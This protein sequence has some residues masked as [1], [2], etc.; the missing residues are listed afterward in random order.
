MEKITIARE[1]KLALYQKMVSSQPDAVVKGDTIPYTSQNGNMY[2]FLTK[3]SVV[4]LRLPGVERDRF[5]E[6]Y[7]TGLVHQYGIV[8]KEY[9]VVPDNLLKNAAEVKAWFRISHEYVI[10]LKPKPTTKSKKKK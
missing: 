1:E 8:Q 4:G 5:L 2:S 7:K 9:V 10:S 3:E 6:K